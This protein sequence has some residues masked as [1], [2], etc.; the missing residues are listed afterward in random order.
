MFWDALAGVV[1]GEAVVR[2]QVAEV[3]RAPAEL[4]TARENEVAYGPGEK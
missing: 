2:Q 4:G 1:P 3:G